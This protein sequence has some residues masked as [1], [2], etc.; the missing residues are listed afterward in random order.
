MLSFQTPLWK[1]LS[2]LNP[3]VETVVYFKPP[4]YEENIN[5]LQTP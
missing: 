5:F 1:L 4:L 3:F 2:I